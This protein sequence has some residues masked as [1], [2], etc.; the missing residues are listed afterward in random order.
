MPPQGRPLVSEQISS[1]HKWKKMYNFDNFLAARRFHRRRRL[2]AASD[3][4]GLSVRLSVCVLVCVCLCVRVCLCVSVC[5]CVCVFVCLCVCPS[6]RLSVCPSVR[7]SVCPSVR[8][9]V[10]PSVRL[11]RQSLPGPLAKVKIDLQ[12]QFILLCR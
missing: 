6:V 3:D 12:K 1:V 10:C 7:L 9:S 4:L 11:S 5:L 2:Q 8:L